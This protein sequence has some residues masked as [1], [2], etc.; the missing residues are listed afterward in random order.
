MSRP[1][2]TREQW[3]RPRLATAERRERSWQTAEG[4]EVKASYGPSD[5]EDFSARYT[6]P[7]QP[8]YLRGPYP[9]R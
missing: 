4:I 1:D 8:P 6:M 2:F 3:R 9:T 7:G 5:V